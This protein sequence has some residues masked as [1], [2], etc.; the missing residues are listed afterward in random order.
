MTGRVSFGRYIKSAFKNRWNLLFFG[1]GLLIALMSGRA[2]VVLPMVAA[3]EIL[4]LGLLSTNA[5]YQRL[6]DARLLGDE[7]AVTAQ[8][9]R[10]RFE[11]LY[12]GLPPN[13]CQM[14]DGLRMR[15][16]VL[17][18]LATPDAKDKSQNA[19]GQLAQAQLASVN[20]LLWVYLKLLHT[21]ITLDSFFWQVDPRELDTT[22][23]EA[24]RLFAQL[25]SG[26]DGESPMNRKKRKSIEDTLATVEARRDNLRKARENQEYVSLEIRRIEAKLTGIAELAV[27][28]HNPGM[29]TDD[30]DI[31]AS[32]IEATEEA[33]GELHSLTGLTVDD[34]V[35]A[36]EILSAASSMVSR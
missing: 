36:P 24:R 26:S 7:S 9:M 19:V 2:D 21:K 1:A 34:D 13:E 22:E 15:C 6:T 23:Q 16:L 14:F 4:Y 20:K 35:M 17:A 25:P 33:I 5:R 31:V 12:A 30:I 18:N 11:K 28:R 32:S 10:A 27:N 3:G 8:M 29:L